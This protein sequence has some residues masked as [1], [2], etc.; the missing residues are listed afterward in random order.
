M[1]RATVALAALLALAASSPGLSA[2]HSSQ[3]CRYVIRTVHGKRERIRVCSTPKPP[4][5][6]APTPPTPP[7]S[8]GAIKITGFGFDRPE[9]LQVGAD[10]LLWVQT[11][12]GDAVYSVD[13]TANKV[14]TQITLANNRICG[15]DASISG[16][17]WLSDC[18][19]PGTPGVSGVMRIDPKAEVVTLT[20]P[21]PNA[22]RVVAAAG[23]VWATDRGGNQVWRIDPA[24]GAVLAKIP[25]GSTPIDIV[26]A[27]GSIWVGNAADGTVSRIDPTSNTLTA[28]IHAGAGDPNQVEA[29]QAMAAGGGA[30]WVGNGIDNKL[31]K[32]DTT[33][34]AVTPIDI[35]A[36][37]RVDF[38]AM[39]LSYGFDSVFVLADTCTIVR[40]DPATNTVSKRY[41]ICD[42]IKSVAPATS[43]ITVAFGSLWFSFPE[44]HVLW[45]MQP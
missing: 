22:E 32:I 1:L 23:S 40:I 12:G 10:G 27:D 14:V 2:R 24:S 20:V 37:T 19:P 15:L 33:T 35:G 6:P 5:A 7:A 16:S 31:Y 17:I 4:P 26:A 39:S 28:T 8:L 43:A 21:G 38:G 25:V 13:P 30:V 44:N 29:A 11:H 9:T 45:R 3:R 41:T 18:G 42:L 36:G 34:N